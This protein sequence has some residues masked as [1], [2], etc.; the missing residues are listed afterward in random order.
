MIHGRAGLR[1]GRLF[2]SKPDGPIDL[3]MSIWPVYAKGSVGKSDGGWP[4]YEPID[5]GRPT[6]FGNSGKLPCQTAPETAPATALHIGRHKFRKPGSQF[7]YYVSSR[8]WS[9]A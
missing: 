4:V 5:D 9:I 7:N 1:Q 8:W 2:E 6:S 3:L